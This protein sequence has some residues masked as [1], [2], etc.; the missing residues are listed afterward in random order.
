MSKLGIKETLVF[1]AF[2]LKASYENAFEIE[3]EMLLRAQEYELAYQVLFS[4]LAPSSVL[5]GL[6]AILFC[7]RAGKLSLK[8][9]KKKKKEST[10]KL[11]ADLEILDKNKSKLSSAWDRGGGIYWKYLSVLKSIDLLRSNPNSPGVLESLLPDL[12]SLCKNLKNWKLTT[13][14]RDPERLTEKF[15]PIFLADGWVSF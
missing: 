1:R 15:V 14:Q 7:L 4:K 12:S 10:K 11:E 2:A 9:K 5:K 3:V 13:F 8:K 6:L